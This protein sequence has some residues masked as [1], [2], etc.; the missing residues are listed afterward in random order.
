MFS[1]VSDIPKNHI[2]PNTSV[3]SP[4]ELEGVRWDSPNV[5]NPIP[6]VIYISI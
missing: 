2:F 1:V 6:K 3:V 5:D 4:G